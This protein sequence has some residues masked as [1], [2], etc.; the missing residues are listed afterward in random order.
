M[1]ADEHHLESRQLKSY[2]HNRS[3]CHMKEI[4]KC[5]F[6]FYDSHF[7]PAEW[8]K[9]ISRQIPYQLETLILKS[10]WKIIAWIE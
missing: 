7:L 9:I 8:S 2:T 4:N 1:P 10:F 6:M 5:S 3:P